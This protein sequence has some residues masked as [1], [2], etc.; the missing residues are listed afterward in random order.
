VKEIGAMSDT[1]T[2]D[3]TSDVLAD[4]VKEAGKP[5]VEPSRESRESVSEPSGDPSET[6]SEEAPD[7]G[8]AVRDDGQPFTRKDHTALAEALKKAR[9][10]A[11]DTA[12][13][14]TK[15][16]QLADADTR[17]MEKFKP[18]MVKAAARSAFTEAGLSLPADRADEV[19][20]RAVKLLDTD[21]LTIT[22][23]GTVDGLAEQVEAIRADFPDLFATTRKAPRI[24]AADRKTEPAPPKS[25]AEKLAASLMGRGAA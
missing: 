11:R 21:A 6:L 9:K 17:A 20:A 19:F 24:A 15:L 4:A 23:D 2:Q 1:E 18:L 22:D 8:P 13:E 12:A 10:E 16:K 14:L 5:K 25:A 7:D 3:T